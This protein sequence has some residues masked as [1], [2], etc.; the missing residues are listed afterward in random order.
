LVINKFEDPL[1]GEFYTVRYTDKLL[2]EKEIG[3]FSSQ[4]EA[5][6]VAY[7]YA[8]QNRSDFKF[9]DREAE[10]KK[11]PGTEKQIGLFR[12]KGFINSIE[13]LTLGQLGILIDSGVLYKKD[14]KPDEP[15]NIHH[16]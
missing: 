11:R 4:S 5:F 13:K 9:S 6:L 12:Q 15:D 7:E 10:Y 3:K 8:M 16:F 14:L 2:G 1:E